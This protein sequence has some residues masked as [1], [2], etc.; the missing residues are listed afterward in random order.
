MI[1]TRLNEQNA[2]EFKE[3]IPAELI[4][5]LNRA[6]IKGIV[7]TDENA[8]ELLSAVFWELKN[9]EEEEL[10]VEAEILW[11]Y[12]K[13][14]ADGEEVLSVSELTKDKG[15]IS[16]VYFELPKPRDAEEAALGAAGFTLTECE[17]RDLYVTVDEIAMLKVIRN[18]PDD[19]VKPLSLISPRQFKGGVM[20]C[21]FHER[22]GLLDDLPFLPMSRF[23][24]D[25]SCCIE[26][27]DKVNGF[28]LTHKLEDGPYRVELFAAMM[29][30]AKIHLLNMIRFS[31]RALYKLKPPDEK[32]LLRRHNK[33]TMELV[34]KLFPGKKGEQAVRGERK[35]D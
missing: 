34:N 28:L 32:V 27:D 12:A 14:A 15:K 26:T 23:D 35:G 9:M 19:Y 17:S 7:G 10:P 24:P 1:L 3:L 2:K 22:Y 30:D 16:R 33:A 4:L 20:T 8:K 31:A 18:K 21:V 13:T 6:N 11:F 29:P 5:D 25:V